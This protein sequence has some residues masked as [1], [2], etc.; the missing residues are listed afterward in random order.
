MELQQRSIAMNGK[1]DTIGSLST[2]S[3][4][5]ISKFE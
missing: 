3:N 1:I 5:S 2:Y 4:S